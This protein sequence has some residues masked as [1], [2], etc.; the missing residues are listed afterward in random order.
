MVDLV[1]KTLVMAK[2]PVSMLDRIALTIRLAFKIFALGSDLTQSIPGLIGLAIGLVPGKRK[3]LGF[4]PGPNLYLVNRKLY[5]HLNMP[6]FPSAAFDRVFRAELS[7]RLGQTSG[8]GLA[9]AF[10]A[11]TKKCGL[12]CEHCFE[13]AS[14]NRQETLSEEDILV[15]VNRLIS[16][17]VGQ[18]FFSGGEPVNRF[19]TL[20]RVLDTFRN[21]PTEFWIITSAMGLTENRIKELK[22]VGLTGIMFSLDHYD[23]N[24]HDRF[25]GRIGCH[26]NALSS[27]RTARDCELATA[28]SLCASNKF[29]SEPFLDAYLGLARR[30]G[31]GFVQ[32][33]EPKPI[34]RYAHADVA[35][36]CENRKLLEATFERIRRGAK[37]YRGYPIVSYPDY[38]RRLNG[39]IGGK[40]FIYIDTDGQVFPCPFCKK[41]S[42]Q[43]SDLVPGRVC[44]QLVCPA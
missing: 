36:T 20:I 15:E 28:L 22:S 8:P 33:L 25:R 4:G 40:R 44:G 9:T 29:I 42:S 19:R 5:W 35:L 16:L 41:T 14:L 32:V 38:Y 23:P 12:N 2:P 6:G 3:A 10:V 37:R 34:G 26:Q 43:L 24:E 7:H 21:S 11:I 17:G 13:W 18:I 31:V 27:A 1:T 30:L 39:C